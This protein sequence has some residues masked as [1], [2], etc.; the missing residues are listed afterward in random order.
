MLDYR[1]ETFLTL[2]KT[3]NYRRTAELLNITQPAVTQHIKYLEDYY[4][5]ELFTY[6]R[7]R[8]S[9]TQ[10]AEILLRYANGQN[11]QE[12]RLR[13]A[14]TGQK[15]YH[16][17]IGTTKTIGAYAIAGHAKQFLVESGNS[18]SVE[19][20]NTARILHLL[21]EG[22]LDFALI[23]GLF[24]R[25]IYASRLYR[26]EPYVGL[27]SREHPFAGR[28]VSLA[29]VLGET[30]ITREEGSG[31][32]SMLEGMLKLKNYSLGDFSRVVSIGNPALITSLVAKNAGITFAYETVGRQAPGVAT[33][34]V[35]G[36]QMEGEFNY[37]FLPNTDAE[38]SVE[39]FEQ[40]RPA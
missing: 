18:L 17:S 13:D 6:D 30:L 35:K 5:C 22:K 15:G 12:T 19:T 23:E 27:C 24:D 21:D 2:C 32:R 37:V 11:Y 33:F 40:Y 10:Q 31:T 26:T 29:A 28:T 14:L 16:L 38:T 34:R 20:D 39:I 7:R 8:L 3:M 36:F 1:M 4:G 9:M 25:G